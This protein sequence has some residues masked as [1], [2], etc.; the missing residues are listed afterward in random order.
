[1]RNMNNKTSLAIHIT[2]KCNL[3]CPGCYALAGDRKKVINFEDIK[4]AI[5]KIKP[6]NIVFFGGEAILEPDIIRKTMKEFP[7]ISYALHTNGTNYTLDTKDIY[8]SL[9]RIILTL[10]SLN[11]EWLSKYKHFTKDDYQNLTSLLEEFKD[12]ITITHNVFAANNDADFL[13]DIS[14]YS[15]LPIDW[16]VFITKKEW[17]QFFPYFRE[18][19]LFWKNPIN[20]KPKLRLL[21]DGTITR[22]M[23]G[24]YNLCHITEW[25]ESFLDKEL[26]VSNTCKK[27]SYFNVCLA[28][29][30]FPHFV[31]DIIDDINYEPHFCK[32]TKIFWRKNNV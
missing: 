25:N 14:E 7:Q 10:D 31:K 27:C 18:K 17:Q 28:C 32:F 1:M 21:T 13:S 19:M 23:R 2:N 30:Q 4:M 22:D 29:T 15:K 26:P 9:D 16:Y 12:K 5:E 24:I 20:V 6:K 8:K 3:K 11:Y